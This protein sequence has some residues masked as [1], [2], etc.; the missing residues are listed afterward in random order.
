MAPEII[1]DQEYDTT[2]DIYAYG[3]VCWELWTH[4]LPFE[5]FTPE[6]YEY[7][8]CKRGLRLPDYCHNCCGC[9][10]TKPNKEAS[11]CNTN[12]KH[13]HRHQKKQQRHQKQKIM[14]IIPNDVTVLLS[15]TWK[16]KPS[17]RIR[18]PN[19]QEQF[20]LLKR[21]EEL[22]LEERELLLS[23]NRWLNT[24]G[25]VPTTQ[26]SSQEYLILTLLVH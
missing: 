6:L 3:V 8:V 20:H 26:F 24:N 9:D 12:N 21:L 5:A 19:I 15:H 18:W 1:L 23:T 22:K 14:D 25:V 13:R 16:H 2:C 7:W 10:Y 11:N 17:D 4:C